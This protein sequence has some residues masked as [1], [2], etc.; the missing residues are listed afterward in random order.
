VDGSVDFATVH[1]NFRVGLNAQADTVSADVDDDNGDG[2]VA[3][4]DDNGL[5]LFAGKN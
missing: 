1:G 4:T 5:V 2:I 3:F